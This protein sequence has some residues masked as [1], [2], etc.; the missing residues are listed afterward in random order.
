MGISFKSIYAKITEYRDFF[1]NADQAPGSDKSEL[2]KRI[3]ELFGSINSQKE[4][5]SSLTKAEV[6]RV[7]CSL[8][9]I[10][11]VKDLNSATQSKIAAISEMCH[12]A[13]AK[14]DFQPKKDFAPNIPRDILKV[15]CE[16]LAFKDFLNFLRVSKSWNDP[17]LIAIFLQKFAKYLPIVNL[18]ALCCRAGENLEELILEDELCYEDLQKVAAAC[19][20]LKKIRLSSL[21][22]RGLALFAG[23]QDM[24]SVH[25]DN[26]NITEEEF[27]SFLQ[28]NKQISSLSLINKG[29]ISGGFTSK[30][31]GDDLLLL[32]DL[33]KLENFL[34]TNIQ[35][36]NWD[37]AFISLGK[38]KSLKSLSVHCCNLSSKSLL[39]LSRLTALQ[40]LSL[41]GCQ[42]RDADW[43]FLKE[44]NQLQ[45]LALGGCG[46]DDEDLGKLVLLIPQ[47]TTLCLDECKITNQGVFHLEKLEQLQHISLN[48]CTTIDN[49]G[50]ASLAK[51][52][53]L[54]HIAL[55]RCDDITKEGLNHLAK[56]EDLRYLSL[57][58]CNGIEGDAL[59][60][61][62]KHT[63]LRHISLFNSNINDESIKS[64]V[65]HTHL[66][67]I[68]LQ[69]CVEVTD[70]GVTALEKLEHLEHFVLSCDNLT[71]AS[72]V[73]FANH[74]NLKSLVLYCGKNITNGDLQVLGGLSQLE[75]LELY[76]FPQISN[77]GLAFLVK[78]EK[79]LWLDLE[80]VGNFTDKSLRTY[81]AKLKQLRYLG[82]SGS[83]D[84]T[85]EGT[86]SLT[87]LKSLKILNLGRCVKLSDNSLISIAELPYLNLLKM[88]SCESIT[89]EAVMSLKKKN[90]KLIFD[91]EQVK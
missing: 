15:I 77:E 34:L 32:T 30:S 61:L 18:V 44:L 53:G 81:V 80:S 3:Q 57:K 26:A 76:A 90:P 56:L 50:L 71:G 31:V 40:T 85:D 65:K 13:V 86:A 43:N 73:S 24:E 67:R 19:P 25:L 72:L 70:A 39:S 60:A 66:Q 48:G 41:N 42:I 79:L 4:F 5:V 9:I 78:L 29:N 21:D 28:R 55:D 63:N 6:D 75:S 12:I 74:K 8:D 17:K 16:N 83:R 88:W 59:R 11:K 22:G 23:H 49:E 20:N 51:H 64:L 14:E 10:A 45:H 91:G 1:T 37:S 38:I 47:L 68:E 62:E 35:E 58:L 52:K 89:S 36:V 82:L 87:S 54:Q 27:R 84:I 69:K 46:L 33:P 2:I 7:I